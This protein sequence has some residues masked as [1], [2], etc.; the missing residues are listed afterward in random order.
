MYTRQLIIFCLLLYCPR[1]FAQAVWKG[2]VIDKITH[3][4]IPGAT[5]AVQGTGKGIPTDEAGRFTVTGVTPTT[6]VVSAVNYAT[7]AVQATGSPL[8][9]ELMPATNKLQEIVVSGS[10]TAQKRS[11]V[12]V[13]IST[14]S[15]QTLAETRASRLDQV[16]NKAT[17]VFM[18]NLGNEQHEMSIRQPLTTKSL[19]LY[20][21]DGIPIRTSG[22]YN[23]NALLEMNMAAT[24]QIEIIRGPSSSL[25]GAEAIGGAVNIIT[26]APPAVAG[27]TVSVQANNTGYKRADFQAGTPLG[28]WG[29]VASGYYA[30]RHNGPID[31]SDFHKTAVTLRADYKAN[32]HLVWS[33][34]VS[35]VDYYS[36]MTGALDSAHFAHRDYSTPYSFTYRKVTALRVKSQ[37]SQQWNSNSQTQVSLVFRD[38]SVKQNPSYYIANDRSNPL[39]AHGQ[40]NNSSFNSYLF[41]A[42][43]Q[44]RFG[45]L[46]SRLVAGI[47]ADISPST[48]IANYIRIQRDS[49]GNYTGYTSTDSALSNYTTGISN[50]ASYAQ[51]EISPLKRLKLVAALRYDFYH[52]NFSNYLPPS[53]SSGAPSTQNNFNRVTPKLGFTYNYNGIGFYGNYSQG[54]VPPQVTE[55]FNGVKVPYLQPQTFFNYEA[56]GWLSLLD[57]KLY[58]DWSVYLMNGTNEIISVKQDDG[59]YLNQ[60][61]GKTRHKG[62]EYG[63]T[64]KPDQQWSFRLSATHA[65]HTFVQDIE[66][67]IDY[68]G[69]EMSGAPHFICNAEAGYRPAFLPHLRLSA[70]WQHLGSYYMDNANSS[71]YAGFDVFNVR[72]GYTAGPL[73]VWINALNL[74][75]RY[76]ATYASKSSYGYSYNLGDPRELTVGLSFRFGK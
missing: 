59:S 76:Y 23:H 64:Y 14:I 58:A 60:N 8:T 46:G 56:G 39:L 63:I 6:L 53:A 43:H 33:N 41:I 15:A 16:L 62:I 49:K 7:Q 12:P 24:K 75:D 2:K 32:E 50:L 69:N 47:S 72:A 51:Y 48:Y 73:E 9:I 10:R 54:Y 25:Y 68:S 61:A 27:G 4:A 66:K 26:V 31:Y 45:W 28:K 44:Q 20:L 21:E 67:G 29:I 57:N 35:F 22:I 70:E 17:G 36:D 11:E 71:R 55:L 37:L 42:Q 18:V 5:V 3:E 13:A 19:F 1:L 74:L 52:Y 34:S 38:N 40:V 65:L 30:N